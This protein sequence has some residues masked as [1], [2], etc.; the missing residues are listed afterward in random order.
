MIQKMPHAVVPVV[1]VMLCVL[2]P[3][4][5]L[6]ETPEN[7]YRDLLP[8]AE[9]LVTVKYVLEAKV[10]GMGNQEMENEVTCLMIAADGLILCSNAAMGGTMG[11]LARMMV[12][13]GG[14]SL[15][16]KQIEVLLGEASEGAKATVV[17]RDTE[18]DLSWLSLDE[19]PESVPRFLDFSDHASLEPGDTFYR[20]RRLDEFFG[21]APAVEAGIISAVV[22]KPRRLLV[23][24]ISSASGAFGLPVFDD[25]GQL[26][27]ITVLQLPGEET[28][29]SMFDASMGSI[30]NKMQDMAGGLVLPASE[31]V[32]ATQLARESMA[33]DEDE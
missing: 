10:P 30:G 2:L 25:R 15:V 9:A 3:G 4:T 33:A 31:V 13:G 26:V 29:G 18:R 23:P 7:P 16:P 1:L 17:A 12:G 28:R 27:G 14:V 8:H 22:D 21:R 32:R 5:A 6:G 19:P 11:L 24:E 20:L